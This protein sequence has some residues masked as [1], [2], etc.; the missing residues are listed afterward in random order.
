MRGGLSALLAT[1]VALTFH[2]GAG[3]QASNL[4]ALVVFIMSFW[5]ATLLAGRA[6]GL[7]SLLGISGFAQLGMHWLTHILSMGQAAGP[8]VLLTQT[9]TPAL[10]AHAHHAQV[11]LTA[12]AADTSA[13][14]GLSPAML[15]AHAAAALITAYA[16]TWGE[17][18]LLSLGES[19]MG[20]TAL[21]LIGWRQP[22]PAPRPAAIPAAPAMVLRTRA[23]A[24][25]PSRGPPVLWARD[26]A[27]AA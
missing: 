24:V 5:T 10:G 11:E 22:A 17:A 21:V 12:L 8:E 27:L 3:G 25:R 9:G 16:L 20:R 13:G 4:A 18:L 23:V 15:A 26:C 1:L 7:A 2:A 6:W 19:A 14:T